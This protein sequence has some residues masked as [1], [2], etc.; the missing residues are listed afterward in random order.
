MTRTKIIGTIGPVSSTKKTLRELIAAGLDVARLNFSHG[1]HQSHK[2]LVEKIITAAE[3]ES[4]TVAIL[5][6]LQ[7]PRIRIGKISPRGRELIAGEIV[8][9]TTEKLKR[10][11]QRLPVTYDKL[12]EDLKIG[13][14][15]LVC[16]G[17]IVL[18]VTKI[19]D[20][21]IH[22]YVEIG[23]LVESYK[24]INLPDS[25]INI[26]A[27]TAKDIADVEFGVKQSLD[28][29]G[30]SFVRSAKDI[31]DLRYL[32]KEKEEILGLKNSVPIRIVAK[33]ER[34]E[35][36]ENLDEIIDA[37]DAIMVARGDLGIEMPAE[38][39]PLIQKMIID[40]CL[41]KAKPVIVATQMLDSMIHNPRPTRAEVSDVAN[42]V[43]DHADALMLSGETAVG[44][45]PVEAVK[46][47]R[48]II[49]KTESSTYDDLVFKNNLQT[50]VDIDEAVSR[51]ANILSVSVDAKLI[52]AASLSGYT[53]RI[54]SRYRPNLPIYVACDDERI[55][56]QLILSWG[57]IPFVLPTCKSIEELIER[58]ILY[59]KQKKH[60]KSGEKLIIIAGEPVGKSGNVNLVEI[61]EIK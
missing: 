48:K 58:S 54:I 39:V 49:E 3:A 59:L 57:I 1:T 4:K 37:A 35:A 8:I 22:C 27:L 26:S 53:G 25:D 28:F 6:D 60:I 16:D 43:I 19:I 55:K 10:N 2:I 61:K 11:D 24:G 42:A 30:L 50:L 5:G 17:L 34:R 36:V 46:Y 33:I 13:E 47:M 40:K 15:V 18:K 12:H 38:D 14:R 20:K 29:F 41:E 21:N 56:R 45:Y 51:V 23:G 44:A 52:L 9:L 7:G 31:I 32:I